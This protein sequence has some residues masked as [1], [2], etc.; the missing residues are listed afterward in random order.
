MSFDT[1][2]AIAWSTYVGGTAGDPASDISA[3]GASVYVTGSTRS[4]LWPLAQAGPR[5]FGG[6][7]DL[8]IARYTIPR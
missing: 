3:A 4:A 2:G 5:P 8:Y 1:S 6:G 7:S